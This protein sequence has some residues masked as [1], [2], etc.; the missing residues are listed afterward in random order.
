MAN[1]MLV[2]SLEEWEERVLTLTMSYVFSKNEGTLE[3]CYYS[4]RD[5]YFAA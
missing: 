5:S 2:N 1:K 3:Y 4:I